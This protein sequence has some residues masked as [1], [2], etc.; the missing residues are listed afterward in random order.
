[1]SEYAIRR[2]YHFKAKD[3]APLARAFIKLEKK[4]RR[5][6]TAEDIVELAAD[7]TSPF[8]RVFDEAGMWDDQYAAQQARLH[9]ARKIIESI[10]VMITRGNEQVQVRGFVPVRHV[11]GEGEGY[12]STE[13]VINDEERTFTYLRNLQKE[14]QRT[15]EN[16]AAWAWIVQT[17]EPAEAYVKSAKRFAEAPITAPRR[18]ASQA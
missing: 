3:A 10:D 4:L 6:P 5:P 1:M 8:Y 2:G 17:H 14:A 15:A 18:K 7:P 12:T 11:D 16:A 9:F 13:K